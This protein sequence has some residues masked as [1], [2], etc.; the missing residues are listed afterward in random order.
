MEDDD[1]ES[2]TCITPPAKRALGANCT[3]YCGEGLTCQP[4]GA[5]KCYQSNRVGDTCSGDFSCVPP[6]VCRNGVCSANK[7]LG[8][9]CD[10]MDICPLGSACSRPLGSDYSA[11][12]TCMAQLAK[13]ARCL[14][15]GYQYPQCAMGLVC[16]FNSSE[17]TEGWCTPVRSLPLGQWASDERLCMST[18]RNKTGYCATLPPPMWLSKA[19]KDC[20]TD[21]DC[22]V[23]GVDSDDNPLWCDC[24]LAVG[25]NK[26]VCMMDEGF[27]LASL[28]RE[29][30]AINAKVAPHCERDYEI[31]DGIPMDGSCIA[32]YG[33]ADFKSIYCRVVSADLV[34][35]GYRA[36]SACYHPMVEAMCA[37]GDKS[38]ATVT[39]IVNGLTGYTADTPAFRQQL[40]Y[41][42]AAGTGVPVSRVSIDSLSLDSQGKGSFA[43][44]ITPGYPS[45][46]SLGA[47]IKAAAAD[48]TSVLN[49][50]LGG[51]VAGA[52]V[53]TSAAGLIAP[54]LASL[55]ALVFAAFLLM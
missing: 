34:T 36:L 48:P 44:S 10:Y 4:Y 37:G 8:D 14:K 6:R 39:L 51:K 29:Q 15:D 50:A 30:D 53:E 38:K 45:A 22:A 1:G 42:I 20:S 11:A 47:S 23:E 12:T 25:E 52:T 26:K 17:I 32:R 9:A 43:F 16:S 33:A 46:S 41:T 27:L 21:A 28:S 54:G 7:A 5:G 35:K 2:C 18:M 55:L 13:G 24:T 19:F 40:A 49:T 3:N 31:Q